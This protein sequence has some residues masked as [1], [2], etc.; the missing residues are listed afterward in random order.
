V[1]LKEGL[2]AASGAAA[3][4]EALPVG[5]IEGDADDSNSRTESDAQ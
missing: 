5:T 4:P 1:A 3:V 2:T